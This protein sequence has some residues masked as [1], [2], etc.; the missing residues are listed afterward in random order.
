MRAFLYIFKILPIKI[1]GGQVWTFLEKVNIV[2]VFILELKFFFSNC[3]IKI[4]IFGVDESPMSPDDIYTMFTEK[5]E[6]KFF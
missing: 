2:N 6:R 3:E 1:Q 4:F 5:N